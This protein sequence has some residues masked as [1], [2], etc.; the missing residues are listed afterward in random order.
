MSASP[1]ARSHVHHRRRGVVRRFRGHRRQ[2][3]SIW[4]A[5][6]AVTGPGLLAG[7]SDDDPAGVTTYSIL[8]AEFGYDLLWSIPLSTL[9]LICFHLLAV[10]VGLASGKGLGAVI[11][12]RHGARAGMLVAGFFVLAN[13]GTICAEFAGVAAAGSLANIPPWFSSSLAAVFVI[14]LVVAASFHRV[15]HV[16]LAISTL[17]A[18][19]IAAALLADPDWH[20]VATGLVSPS[21]GLDRAAIVAVTA[22]LGTTLAPWGLAFVQSY[23]VDKGLTH[24][25]WPAERVEVTIGSILTGVIGLFIAV[26]CAAV[27]FPKGVTITDARDAAAALEPLAGQHAAL[28]FGVG[29]VGAALLGAAIVPLSTA[30]TVSEGFG[31]R[32]DLDDPPGRDRFFYGVFVASVVLAAS[33]V[34]IPGVPLV[35]LIYASQVVNAI[36][37]PPLMVMLVLLNRDRRVVGEQRIGRIAA[38][39]SYLGVLVV[40]AALVA[41]A[42]SG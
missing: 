35:P 18:A 22:T 3:R 7:L 6:L 33:I 40:V 11:R 38:G 26:T 24:R 20:A 25:D 10:R 21:G 15:E 30:Y 19:Y 36:F 41:L 9:L 31:R 39:V 27:L 16:L 8:G 1:P 5:L 42:T 2:G 29:L 4:I 23:A 14:V 34:A 12:D 17:L 13:F 37:L 32:G 28:L